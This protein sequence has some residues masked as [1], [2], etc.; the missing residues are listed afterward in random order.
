MISISA[1]IIALLRGG[2]TWQT[3]FS[4]CLQGRHFCDFQFTFIHTKG[5]TLKGKNLLRTEAYCFHSEW[6]LFQKGAKYYYRVVFLVLFPLNLYRFLDKFSRWKIDDIFLT[7]SQNIA[8]TF[9][10]VKWFFLFFFFSGGWK[11]WRQWILF[12]ILFRESNLKRY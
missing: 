9:Q 8:L 2:Y 7:F 11:F 4:H 5:S 6:T 10:S 3:F 1:L 12:A